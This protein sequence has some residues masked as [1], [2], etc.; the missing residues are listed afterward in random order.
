[1]LICLVPLALHL[2]GL[3]TLPDAITT[4]VPFSADAGAV[5][6]LSEMTGRMQYA[7]LET[8]AANVAFIVAALALV[9]WII[10]RNA[11]ALALAG[12][13]GLAGLVDSAQAA[14]A[15]GLLFPSAAHHSLSAWLWVFGRSL[16][17]VLLVIGTWFLFQGRH[18]FRIRA[19]FRRYG[20]LI[21]SSAALVVVFV[22]VA[23][24]RANVLPNAAFPLRHHHL[25][26]LGAMVLYMAGAIWI[27]PILY[28]RSHA[29]LLGVVGLSLIPHAASQAYEI[30]DNITSACLLKTLAYGVPL[31][32]LLWD[33]AVTYRKDTRMFD[34]LLEETRERRRA[35]AEVMA[36]N[37]RVEERVAQRTA[38]LEEALRDLNEFAHMASHDLQEPLRKQMM[39]TQ[40]LL[41]SVD[42]DLPPNA[43]LAVDAIAS[44]AERMQQLVQDLMAL[45]RSARQPMHMEAVEL[46]DCV[47][48]AL[49][50]LCVCVLESGA[51]VTWDPLPE[52]YGDRA[53]LKQL[54]VNLLGNAMKFVDKD[55]NPRIHISVEQV[56]DETVFGVHDNGIGIDPDNMREVF[57]PFHRLHP[58]HEYPGSGVGLS[59]CRKIVERHNG[60]IWCDAAPEGGS[61]FRFTLSP[62]ATG[63][64]AEEDEG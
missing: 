36:M 37:S 25:W 42:S 49:L 23:M 11:V 43:R 64:P 61:H 30:S 4:D 38:E 6:L 20:A 47:E 28:R 15:A 51:N 21:F 19:I 24:A 27:G 48:D 45:S 13:S 31:V 14:I 50:D 46:E 41:D 1:M 7:A 54:F 12:A 63:K 60:V 34:K 17:A 33:Y 40:V 22:I 32:G 16:H 5:S 8:A 39:F 59:I 56:R 53:L 62:P 44:A 26:D 9:H 52:V 2:S 3:T 29:P 35:Q 55:V 58:V 10:R 57:I 18:V